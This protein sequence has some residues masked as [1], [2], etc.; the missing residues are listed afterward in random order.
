LNP[1]LMLPSIF[2]ECILFLAVFIFFVLPYYYLSLGTAHLHSFG[3]GGGRIQHPALSDR[4]HSATEF[5]P[6]VMIPTGLA[7]FEG[8][9]PPHPKS[10]VCA[11]VCLGRVLHPASNSSTNIAGSGKYIPAVVVVVE[12]YSSSRNRGTEQRN[13]CGSACCC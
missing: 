4:V 10:L 6:R 13:T 1:L 9:I 3:N 11:P 5:V 7:V 8:P 12:Y 2:F